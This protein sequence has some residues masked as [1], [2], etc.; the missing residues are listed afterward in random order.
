M[1]LPFRFS[2]FVLSL[3][4]LAGSCRRANLEEESPARG[5]GTGPAAELQTTDGPDKE[6]FRQWIALSRA[7]YD[8]LT[9]YTCLFV[10]RE[11]VNDKL[12]PVEHVQF[13]FKKPLMVYMKW[14][15]KVNRGQEC[16]Y[17]EGHYGGKMIA[18][19]SGLKGLVTLKLDPKGTTAMRNRRHPITE[20]GIGHVIDLLLGDSDLAERH[21]EGQV[22]DKGRDKLGQRE[23]QV[24][25]CILPADSRPGYYCHRGVVGFDTGLALPVMVSVYDAQDRLLEQYRYEDLKVDVGLTDEH[26]DKDNPEYGF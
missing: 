3:M 11:R 2:V 14:T 12:L 9:D 18:R 16:L 6:E 10:Q 4:L 1:R 20:A 13:K 19:G 22:V 7:A 15:G 21:S 26:F 25:E 24:F 23:V 8:A 17:V 5:E